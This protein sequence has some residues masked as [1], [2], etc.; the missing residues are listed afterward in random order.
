MSYELTEDQVNLLQ[1]LI[2][3]DLAHILSKMDADDPK[4]MEMFALYVETGNQ[5]GMN[6]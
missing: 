2:A 6:L 1:G 4:V 5:L 3:H